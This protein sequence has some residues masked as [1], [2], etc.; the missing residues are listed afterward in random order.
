MIRTG[1]LRLSKDEAAKVIMS[2]WTVAGPPL[3]DWGKGV[4]WL[5]AFRGAGRQVLNEEVAKFQERAAAL[6]AAP[7]RAPAAA[8]PAATPAT[9]L[10]AAPSTA[11][12]ATARAQLADG[13]APAPA[14]APNF[15]P[16]RPSAR[17]SGRRKRARSVERIW[18]EANAVET[19]GDGVPLSFL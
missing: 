3:A 2:A 6:A 12:P 8:P 19:D 7:A 5:D 14:P 9:A 16:W 11:A 13:S 18:S 15:L 10:H 4:V 1:A 17:S